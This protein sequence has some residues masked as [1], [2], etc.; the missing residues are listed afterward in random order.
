[1]SKAFTSEE[2]LD[3][4]ALVVPRAPLPAGIPNFVTPRGLELLQ[5]EHHLRELERARLDA[6]AE[7]AE[8]ARA[9]TAWSERTRALE[10]RLQSAALVD[11]LGQP[12]D[13]VRFGAW[14]RVRSEGAR[15]RSY[16]I[17]GVDEADPEQG[18][19]AFTSPLAR[20]LLGLKL[21]DSGFVRTPRGED[22]LEVIAI[23]YE[24]SPS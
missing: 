15:E 24:Q 12:R 21:G 1:V 19:V 4:P 11:P 6:I 14:V 2:T 3:E 22:E 9:L 10:E 13:E 23:D 8:K 5:K 16:Q 18:K 7:P 20:A 17:V